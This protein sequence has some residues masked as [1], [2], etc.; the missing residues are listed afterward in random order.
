M[1]TCSSRVLFG[2]YFHRKIDLFS[3]N[4]SESL[5]IMHEYSFYSMISQILSAVTTIR[6]K[7]SEIFPVPVDS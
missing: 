5:L 7:F 2:Q 6:Y 3:S 1:Y 4:L